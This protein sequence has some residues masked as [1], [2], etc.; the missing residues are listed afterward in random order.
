MRGARGRYA[1][2]AGW[3]GAVPGPAGGVGD[4]KP[5]GGGARGGEPTAAR[6]DA[7]TARL[8]RGLVPRRLGGADADVRVVRQ[9]VGVLRAGDDGGV[10]RIRGGGAGQP[11]DVR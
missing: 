6:A 1:G 3:R 7:D 5:G 9:A 8:D 10:R 11:A 4:G 2:R